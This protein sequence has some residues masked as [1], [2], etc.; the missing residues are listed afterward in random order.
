MPKESDFHARFAVLKKEYEYQINTAEYNVFERKYVY[1]YNRTL[2][3]ALMK[4]ATQFFLGTHDF[5][6][7]CKKNPNESDYQRTIYKLTV[8]Q[9]GGKIIINIVGSGFLRYMVRN[10]VGCLIEVGSSKREPESISA[11]FNHKNRQMSGVKASA[12]GL[13]LKKVFYK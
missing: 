5:T 8:R 2:D 4:K 7:F 12:E 3:V 9:K 6:S 1:Q 13:Y 11:L 10:I